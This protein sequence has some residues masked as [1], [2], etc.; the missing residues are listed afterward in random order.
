MN[1][2]ALLGLLFFIMLLV[3]VFMAIMLFRMNSSLKRLGSTTDVSGSVG[4]GDLAQAAYLAENMLQK[5][6]EQEVRIAERMRQQEVLMED[7]LRKQQEELGRQQDDLRADTGR[8]V[9]ENMES[10]SGV[11]GRNSKDTAAMQQEEMARIDAHM[12]QK[13][14]E[15]RSLVDEKL[16][17]TLTERVSASFQIVNE[18]LEQVHRGL[19]DMQSLARSVGDLKKV[20]GNVKTRGILGEIQL[21]A[22][23]KEILAP[24]QYDMNVAT[25][26]G[27]SKVVEFAVKLPVEGSNF[28]YLPIDAKFPGTTYKNLQEAYNEGDRNLIEECRKNLISTLKNEAKDIHDKYISPPET[29]D[30]A[31][32]F[33]PVEGLYAEAV[34]LGMLEELQRKYHV[35]IAGPGT[36]AALLNTIQMMFRYVAIQKRSTEVWQV[37]GAVKTEFAKFDDVLASTQKKITQANKDLDS[38][39]GVRTRA[40]QRKLADV[41]ELQTADETHKIKDL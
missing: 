39:I 18:R 20:M 3:V 23:L 25:K 7:R 17:Q 28:V 16:Q 4:G 36:M 40:I 5:M 32:L 31:I 19:G 11:I 2:T 34:N 10:F 37:L 30:F 15:M 26:K 13:L 24:E 12:Q 14:D 35:H 27:S 9:R 41:T 6:Q 38:L 1:T 22:I 8:I 29:T 33:I 21:G